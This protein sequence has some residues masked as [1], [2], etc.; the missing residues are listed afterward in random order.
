[1]TLLSGRCKHYYKFIKRK[2]TS[3]LKATYDDDLLGQ[4]S[5]YTWN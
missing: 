5:L 4:K 1:M 3:V 2:F